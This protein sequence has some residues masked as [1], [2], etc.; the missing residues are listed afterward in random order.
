MNENFSQC[1][2]E[3]QSDFYRYMVNFGGIK[4][5]TARDYI[6][7]LKFLSVNYLIDLSLTQESINIIIA[8]EKNE[9]VT[10]KEY[11]TP[12]AMA[13]FRAGLNKF[14]AF[15][16]YDY[17]DKHENE[18]KA[19]INKVKNS[20]YLQ[21]TEKTTI[22][23]ARIGQGT[24]RKDAINYWKTCSF[25]GCNM[26]DLLVASHIKPWRVSNNSERLNYFNSLLLL[27]N[28]DKLFDLGYV[29]VD[30]SGK[31]MLSKLLS[32]ENISLLGI[33][34]FDTCRISEQHK[35]FLEYHNQ[36]CFI[37]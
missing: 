7:R 15:A 1:F 35:P 2:F 17:K 11:S 37:K 30:T 34:E 4:P 22:I 6:S 12:K 31:L 25:T 9:M 24:F 23:Q 36:H 18:I 29:T 28:Y 3:L 32:K 27:P 33:G 14:L 19:E 5:K 13:D 21:D 10:R 20:A 26:L 8:Q 16:K